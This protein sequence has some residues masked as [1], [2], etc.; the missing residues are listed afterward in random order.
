MGD[1]KFRF[2]RR[3]LLKVGALAGAGV[4]IRFEAPTLFQGANASVGVPQTPLPGASV[5]QFVTPLPTFVG[6]RVSG[7]SLQIGMQE[8]QQFVLP[9]SFYGS[10]ADGFRRGTY[11]WGYAVGT[12]AG[13]TPQW[14]G[15]T[16]EVHRG[17][18]VTVLRNG[19]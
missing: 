18:P 2:T 15:A 12:G 16:V 10:L 4:A 17:T 5:S 19:R 7:S 11:V 14:P 13:A 6:N 9:Y 8:F 3:D 1:E